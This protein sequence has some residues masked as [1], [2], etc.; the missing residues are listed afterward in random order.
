MPTVNPRIT[1]TLTPAV[2][3][4]LKE[5]SRLTGNSQSAFVG[6]LLEHSCSIFERMVQVLKA[7]ERV[8][9]Q[10]NEDIVSSLEGVQLRLEKQ[11]GNDLS[12]FGLAEGGEKTAPTGRITRRSG[13]IAS[14]PVATS[15]TST[16]ISNRGVTSLQLGKKVLGGSASKRGKRDPV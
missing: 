1:I 12:D 3:T 14:A 4:V 11:L 5:M 2:S 9:T 15:R 10:V 6:E 7:A 8:K 13:R 16:P